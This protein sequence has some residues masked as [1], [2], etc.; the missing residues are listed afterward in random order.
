VHSIKQPTRNLGEFVSTVLAEPDAYSI[1]DR[2]STKTVRLQAPQRWVLGVLVEQDGSLVSGLG[3][4]VPDRN[5]DGLPI[6]RIPGH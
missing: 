4:G 1:L 2:R 5:R 3:Q 6:D